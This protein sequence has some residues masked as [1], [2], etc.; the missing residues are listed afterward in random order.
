M[1]FILYFARERENDDN[2]QLNISK[3]SSLERSEVEGLAGDDKEMQV[4]LNEFRDVFKDELP[5]GLPPRRDIDHVKM[6]N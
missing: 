3:E 4:V 1:E 5:D 6:P 2:A